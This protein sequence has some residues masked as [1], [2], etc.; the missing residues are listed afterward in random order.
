[1][2]GL[3]ASTDV[4]STQRWT[5]PS[6]SRGRTYRNQA[7]SSATQKAWRS[8]GCALAIRVAGSPGND[9]ILRWGAPVAPSRIRSSCMPP[10]VGG[11]ICAKDS[12]ARKSPMTSSG[13]RGSSQAGHGI[14]VASAI[15]NTTRM[16][17]GGRGVEPANGSRRLGD[18]AES[19]FNPRP[20]RALRTCSSARDGISKTPS[21]PPK[22]HLSARKNS[23]YISCL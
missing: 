20:R 17:T 7:R 23:L 14:I 12:V 4:V 3:F 11:T 22:K 10:S 15:V 9:A 1:M 21:Q 6:E 5:H 2:L 16:A 13:K 19:S 8:S 18:P